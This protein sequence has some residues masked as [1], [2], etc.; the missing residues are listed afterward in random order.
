MSEKN[1]RKE[2][3]R[4]KERERERERQEKKER[5]R[6]RGSMIDKESVCA[7]VRKKTKEWK[8]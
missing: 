8:E 1:K 6:R 2:R 7:R 3:D 5:Y 4:K